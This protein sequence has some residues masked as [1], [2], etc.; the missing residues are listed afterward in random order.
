MACVQFNFL[1]H[2]NFQIIQINISGWSSFHYKCWY[3]HISHICRAGVQHPRYPN[4]I[5]M[6]LSARKN[7]G[8]CPMLNHQARYHSFADACYRNC[9]FCILPNFTQNNNNNNN[10]KLG[11]DKPVLASCN[12]LFKGLPS[13]VV[14]SVC[15]SALFLAFCCS[16]LFHVLLSSL[17][18]TK[19]ILAN[20]EY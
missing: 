5:G 11:L 7:R 6:V 10:H 13:L 16:F 17:N 18:V 15:N 19:I 8:G 4:S 1:L 2:G 3:L 12:S 20:Y 9:N 14:H